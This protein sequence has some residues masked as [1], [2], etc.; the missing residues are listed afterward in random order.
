[1]KKKHLPR[2]PPLPPLPPLVKLESPSNHVVQQCNHVFKIYIPKDLLFKILDLAG[3]LAGDTCESGLLALCL[4]DPAIADFCNND[5]FWEELCQRR[6]WTRP[7]RT[8]GWHQRPKTWREQFFKWCKLRFEPDNPDNSKLRGKLEMLLEETNGTGVMS[9][10]LSKNYPEELKEYGPIGSWDVSQV[11]DMSF[12]FSRAKEFNADISEWDVSNVRNMSN[13]FSN[14]A[15]FNQNISNW[16]VSNVTQMDQMFFGAKAF[17][18]DLSKWKVLNVKDM[19]K[20]FHGASAFNKDISSWN[21]SSVRKMQHM[22]DGA[23]AFNRN[24][25]DWG[26]RGLNINVDVHYMF[27][28]SG[29]SEQNQPMWY[30]K[31]S[32]NSEVYLAT[33]HVETIPNDSNNSNHPEYPD[34][35][36]PPSDGRSNSNMLAELVLN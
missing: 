24:L 23:T 10:D 30:H 33:Q 14:A 13:M 8:E 11:T 5:D 22:F 28:R 32:G 15:A 3:D 20:M 36:A 1:M 35:V 9:E 34:F 18:Q 29:V 12:M 17:N 7:D 31:E 19:E 21:V 26:K 25:T 4:G 2:L 16:N 27:N 6:D